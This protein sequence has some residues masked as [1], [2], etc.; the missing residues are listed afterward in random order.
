MYYLKRLP[1]LLSDQLVS[2]VSILTDISTRNKRAA[3]CVQTSTN[4]AI[5]NVLFHYFQQH[6][7]G[8]E[9][10]YLMIVSDAPRK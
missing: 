9:E 4:P 2:E 3:T 7:M 5:H 8:K 1:G 6:P 10:N